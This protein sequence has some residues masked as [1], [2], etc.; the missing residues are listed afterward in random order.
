[1]DLLNN[2]M[3]QFEVQDDL[4]FLVLKTKLSFK[5]QVLEKEFLIELEEL[6][7]AYQAA[8]HHPNV[9]PERKSEV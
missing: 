4:I 7:N 3:K 9:D 2:M 5:D 6:A 1:M 8:H